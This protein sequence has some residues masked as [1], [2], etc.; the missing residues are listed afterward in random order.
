MGKIFR[1]L[2]S[3]EKLEGYTFLPSTRLSAT[4]LRDIVRRGVLTL[5]DPEPRSS[6]DR[7]QIRLT[8]A[9]AVLLSNPLAIWLDRRVGQRRRLTAPLSGAHGRR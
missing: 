8:F 3:Q 5:A 2:C 7:F 1:K 6:P 9:L 4:S